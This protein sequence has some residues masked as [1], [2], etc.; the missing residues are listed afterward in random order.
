MIF[1]SVVTWLSNDSEATATSGCHDYKSRKDLVFPFEPA[2]E[3]IARAQSSDGLAGI[4]GIR[5]SDAR[6]SRLERRAT[7]F[8]CRLRRLWSNLFAGLSNRW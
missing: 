7:C 3:N 2:S 5:R 8:P 6:R 1:P 4:H